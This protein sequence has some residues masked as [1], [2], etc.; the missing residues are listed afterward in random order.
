M[1][2]EIQTETQELLNALTLQN[3]QRCMESWEKLG[4][5][6]NAQE[7]LETRHYGKQLFLRSDSPKDVYKRQRYDRRKSAKSKRNG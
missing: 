6:Y 4:Q 5:L 3:F 7:D 2:E 1:I